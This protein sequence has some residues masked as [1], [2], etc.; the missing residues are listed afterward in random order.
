M[1]LVTVVSHPR[2]VV[3]TVPPAAGPP[4][5][6]SRTQTGRRQVSNAWKTRRVVEYSSRSVA[7]L[8]AAACGVRFK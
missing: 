4:V 7:E 8:L 1:S 3:R 6:F 2:P 5:D